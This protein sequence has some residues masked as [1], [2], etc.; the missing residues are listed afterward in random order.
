MINIFFN[1]RGFRIDGSLGEVVQLHDAPA[2]VQQD[3][4]ALYLFRWYVFNSAMERLRELGDLPFGEELLLYSDSRLVEELNGE[5]KPDHIFAS[6]SRAFYIK[7]DLPRFRRIRID[8]CA[9]TA[10]QRKLNE[11]PST[12]RY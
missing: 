6:E 2:G 10:I 4:Q 8:K 9:T 12:A 3:A 11:S 1:E 7:H 5:L